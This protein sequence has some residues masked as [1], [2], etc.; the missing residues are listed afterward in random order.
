MGYEVL[1]RNDS[2]VVSKRQTLG[3]CTLV[4]ALRALVG[5]VL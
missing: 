3:G 2:A 5:L 1:F 4:T